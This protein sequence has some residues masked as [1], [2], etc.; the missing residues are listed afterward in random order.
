MHCKIGFLADNCHTVVMATDMGVLILSQEGQ[1]RRDAAA[2]FQFIVSR[3][4]KAS[5]AD[6]DKSGIDEIDVTVLNQS[7]I[8]FG[9][10]ADESE[11]IV[12]VVVS[13][14]LL[15][16]PL[17]AFTEAYVAARAQPTPAGLDL[18]SDT[19]HC[20]Y[21]HAGEPLSNFYPCEPPLSISGKTFATVEHYYQYMKHARDDAAYAEKI[22]T[23]SVSSAHILGGAQRVSFRSDWN[24]IRDDVYFEGM[25]AKF[26][27]H[28]TLQRALLSTGDKAL[29]QVDS[30]LHWG[31]CVPDDS[32]DGLAHGNNAGGRALQRVRDE[33][34]RSLHSASEP[35]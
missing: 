25:R 24:S 31:M 16:V 21:N 9:I 26:T 30:D 22:R 11:C 8:D 3:Q 12:A 19:V 32:A 2:A 7:L 29:V 35:H 23:S 20:Y 28:E 33:I 6:K 15:R 17:D 4:K 14:G 1:L 10:S 5:A 18:T 13:K 27:Q 34:L